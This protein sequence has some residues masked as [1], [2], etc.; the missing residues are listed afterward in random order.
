MHQ[1][2][3]LQWLHLTDLSAFNSVEALSAHLESQPRDM[4]CVFCVRAVWLGVCRCACCRTVRVLLNCNKADKP[5]SAVRRPWH[6]IE[7]CGP[8]PYWRSRARSVQRRRT[9][10]FGANPPCFR[11]RFMY[12]HPHEIV[13]KVRRIVMTGPRGMEYVTNLANVPNRAAL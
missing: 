8:S 6:R 9:P 11:P 2:S 1:V 12:L 7:G 5:R 4:R 13:G 10:R 3:T